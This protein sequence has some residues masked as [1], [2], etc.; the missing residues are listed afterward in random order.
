MKFLYG[1]TES[2]VGKSI[3]PDTAKLV[4]NQMSP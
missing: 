3:S 1:F 2:E 4:M